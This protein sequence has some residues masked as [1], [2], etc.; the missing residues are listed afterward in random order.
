MSLKSGIRNAV[1]QGEKRLQQLRFASLPTPRDGWP[2]LLGISFPKSGTHLLD[3]ILLGF[4]QVAP[5][6]RR[7]RSFYAEYEGES[8]RKRS[9][10][11]TR[12]W[13]DSL[14]PLDVTSAHL[15]ATP[16]VLQR[17]SSPAFVSYFIYR[18]PRDVAVSHA[19]YVSE[20]EA[21]HVHHDFYASLP[22]FD[23][24]LK[25]SIMGRSDIDIEFP[26]IAGR[27]APYMGWLDHSEVLKLRFEELV[28]ERRATLE[29]ILDHFLQRVP[30]T[31]PRQRILNGLE[32]SINPKRSPTFRSGKTGEWR[33]YF[34]PEHKTL[35]K[36][37][38]GEMLVKLG[39][40]R[41]SNW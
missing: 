9:A 41:D 8:G 25:V 24:R 31:A 28:D 6:S 27:F 32:S 13:L 10:A 12:S 16:E 15:F 3:Q 5:F 14:R 26:D 19:F 34:S 17:V 36:S 22:D 37:V 21:D 23:A 29:R 40:E 30:L 33:K 38:S 7:L 20:M 39:Y 11:E 35:F 1:F 18:D 4:S 2:I